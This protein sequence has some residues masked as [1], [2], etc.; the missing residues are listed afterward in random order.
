VLIDNTSPEQIVSFY[1]E[2]HPL[3]SDSDRDQV[4]EALKRVTSLEL[5]LAEGSKGILY[6]EGTMD[7]DLLEAWAT[8]LDH[9]FKQW[10]SALPFWHNNQGRSPKEARAH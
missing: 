2:A 1:R 3:A 4:R 6:L 7:F 10:F 5:L 9:T 8:V